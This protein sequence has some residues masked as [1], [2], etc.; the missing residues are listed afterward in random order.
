MNFKILKRL[1]PCS[2]RTR[3][4]RRRELHPSSPYGSLRRSCQQQSDQITFK[5]L[6]SVHV[7]TSDH[8]FKMPDLHEPFNFVEDILVYLAKNKN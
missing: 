5:G 8:T 3:A 7:I 4:H 6:Y 1:F 2:V